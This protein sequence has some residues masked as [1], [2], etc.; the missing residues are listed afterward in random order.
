MTA[1]SLR[2]ASHRSRSAGA[3][4]SASWRFCRLRH[5]LPVSSRSLTAMS[6]RPRSLRFATTFDPMNPAPPVTSSISPLSRGTLAIEKI[7]PSFAPVR[8]PAQ[9]R[10]DRRSRRNPDTIRA[11]DAGMNSLFRQPARTGHGPPL[12]V[13]PEPGMS[14]HS[15]AADGPILIVPYMWIGDFVRCHSVVKLLQARFPG[16][17]I[18]L[19]TTDLCAPL[20]D[21][22]PGVRQGIVWNLPR[23]RLA[24]AERHALSRRLRAER[25]GMALVMP[26]TWKS[27]LAPFL[28]GI[29]QRVG[30]FGELR[31]GVVN[32]VRWGERALPR[33]VDR[34]ASL[35]LPRDAPL[36]TQWPAPEPVVALARGAVGPSKRWPVGAYAVLA[37]RLAEQGSTVAIVG[38]PD[39]KPLAAE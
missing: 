15:Q 38:G 17:P 13:P 5:L 20:V 32:D 33:M 23:G 25:Y 35:A 14:T 19:L 9:H 16:R 7:A 36:P 37:R 34:C 6:V 3:T 12:R 28:A 1:S 11:A 22:M 26:R 2:P 30:F 29:P 31:L 21:Y 24:V 10:A 18:D 27:A 39:E 8:T 4:T